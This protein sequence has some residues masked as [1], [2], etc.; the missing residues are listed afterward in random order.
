MGPQRAR[1]LASLALPA[2]ALV[3]Y[4]VAVLSRPQG[5]VLTLLSDDSFYYFKIACNLL[6]GE[7][8]TFDGI[9]PTNGFHPLWMLVVVAV[10]A[11]TG[12]GELATP[13]AVLLL[14]GVIATA[15]LFLIHRTVERH[16]APGYGLVA[17]AAALLPNILIAMLNG[18]ETGLQLLLGMALVGACYR[19]RLLAPDVSLRGLAVLGLLIGLVVLSRLD[20]VF[21]VAAAALMIAVASRR[22]PLSERLARLLYLGAGF[23]VVVAPY[24]AWNLTAFG[25]LTP[26]SGVAKSAFPALAARMSLSGDQ[27]W[28]FLMLAA[29]WVAIAVARAP[30]RWRRAAA[31]PRGATEPPFWASPVSLL[32]IASALHF[33]HAFLFMAWGVYWWHFTLYGLGIALASS[34]ALAAVVGARVWPR[35]LA[36]AAVSALLIAFSAWTNFRGFPVKEA[37]HAG[38]LAAA[39]WAGDHTREEDVFALVDAGLF[40]YFSHRRVVNLD[41]K[42]NSYDY[43]KRVDL[44]TVDAYLE[45][46]GVRYVANIR[47]RYASGKSRIFIP[48]VNKPSLPL[49][50]DE[51]WEVYRGEPIPSDLPRF[52][53]IPT[54]SFVIWQLPPVSSPSP[55]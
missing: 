15:T 18:L 54:S 30:R 36:V 2:G 38:W 51:T 7:G 28:G 6:A 52:G 43:L 16:I 23:A 40:G 44:G 46:A 8:C 19:H 33:V 24:L 35:R 34:G 47:Y 41:G 14:G 22:L 48:R 29:L 5:A 21:L 1:G 53:A 20:S 26:S 39:R 50:M 4:A 42:A 25:H 17:V 55:R 31:G 32:A 10:S 27:L 9:V 13:V 3:A 12:G 45:S 37:Q 11:C 49:V